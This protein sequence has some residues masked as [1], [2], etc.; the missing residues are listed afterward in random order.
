MVGRRVVT[1][2]LSRQADYRATRIEHKGAETTFR[3]H[4]RELLL[5]EIS[6]G[7]PGRHNVTNAL[8]A[9][10]TAME[11]EVAFTTVKQ[12]L[13]GFTGVQ[14]R[15][16]VRGEQGGALYVDDYAHHPVEIEATLEAAELAYPER[17][18]VAVF[19]PHRYSRVED[20]WDDF[21]ASFNRA[22]EVLVCPVYAAGEKPLEGIDRHSIAEAMTVR[23]HRG[24]VVVDSLDDAVAH[25]QNSRKDGDLVVTLGAGNV[26]SV[27]EGLLL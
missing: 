11:L 13:H 12:A 8:G 26:N 23:G 20:L 15:F 14:R 19:Q 16:T 7:M 10:A 17:R 27:I 25:L 3:V 24:V 2:G 9:I 18:L 5:G 22:N 1:Y 4:Y 21:C 6:L